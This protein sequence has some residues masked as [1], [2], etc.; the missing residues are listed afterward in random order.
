MSSRTAAGV[1]RSATS[2]VIFNTLSILASNNPPLYRSSPCDLIRQR[3][4][5]VTR[6][7]SFPSVKAH[8]REAFVTKV[9]GPHPEESGLAGSPGSVYAKDTGAVDGFDHAGQHQNVLFA[10]H[11][12]VSERIIFR[13]IDVFRLHAYP[14]GTPQIES[15]RELAP[16]PSVRLSLTPGPVGASEHGPGRVD[17]RMERVRCCTHAT[18][19]TGRSSPAVSST[20]AA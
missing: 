20:G 6:K 15:S 4:K 18:L 14:H 10:P 19:Q 8:N 9:L 17:L 5:G 3:Q 13:N 16:Y 2:F 1:A 7:V 12:I 11:G